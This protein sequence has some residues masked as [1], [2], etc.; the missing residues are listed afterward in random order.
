MLWSAAASAPPLRGWWGWLGKPRHSRDQ[1]L[2]HYLFIH[3]FVLA[4]LSL[5]WNKQRTQTKQFNRAV[6]VDWPA[7]KESN[8]QGAHHRHLVRERSGNLQGKCTHGSRTG[9][10]EHRASW[11]CRLRLVPGHPAQRYLL[12][13]T[14]RPSIESMPV[15]LWD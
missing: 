3:L 11:P 13:R 4:G 7:R 5:S 10:V 8:H 2:T 6:A 15:G 9:K 14:S 12:P 1:R